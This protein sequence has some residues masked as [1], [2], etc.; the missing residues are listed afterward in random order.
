MPS[1]TQRLKLKKPKRKS[2][3]RRTAPR[4]KLARTNFNKKRISMNSKIYK[5][6]R[7]YGETKLNPC[8]NISPGA[9]GE[10]SG[11]CVNRSLGG[12]AQP[13]F[14]WGACLSNR[15]TSWDTNIRQINGI[16]VE[17]GT[18]HNQRIG[19]YIWLKKTHCTFQLDMVPTQN[20]NH[21]LIQFRLLVVKA[22][23][24]VTPAGLVYAPQASLFIQ[25][26]GQSNGYLS[27]AS[28]TPPNNVT[29]MNEFQ[30]Q[31]MPINKRNWVV[32]RD[33]RFVLSS[34]QTVANEPAGVNDLYFS[35]K[36]PTR[37]NFVLNLNHFKKTKYQEIAGVNQNYPLNYD[38]KYLVMIFAQPIGSNTRPAGNWQVNMTGVTSYTDS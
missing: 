33:Q 14:Y 2:T 10:A 13:G 15:P 35:S 8:L 4:K 22:R 27:V 9:S 20:A 3:M 26:S 6:L 16:S 25:N 32:F 17:Q 5:A 37:K 30:V 1:F 31:N 19:D 7:N 38:P 12:S 18:E 29:P 11:A 24:A 23:E 34:P 21:G 36:Y 28:G